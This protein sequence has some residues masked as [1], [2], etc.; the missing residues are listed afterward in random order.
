MHFKISVALELADRVGE[1]T[2]HISIA[3]TQLKE[4]I[5]QVLQPQHP[6][7]AA[8]RWCCRCCC[9]HVDLACARSPATMACASP[10]V[11]GIFCKV[12]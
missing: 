8:M 10:P 12:K 3:Q 9:L 1:A 11:N 5:K 4:L 2:E 7:H 6:S